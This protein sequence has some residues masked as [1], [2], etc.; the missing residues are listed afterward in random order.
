MSV[1]P[2]RSFVVMTGFRRLDSIETQF[3]LPRLVMEPPLVADDHPGEAPRAAL[4]AVLLPA[5]TR[6]EGR[7]YVLFS[8]GRDSSAIL[9]VAVALA[10]RVGADDPLPVTVIHPNAPGSDEAD[11]QRL[12]LDHL[13]IGQRKVLKFDGEQAW[14]GDSAAHSLTQNGLLWPP[15]VHLHGAI[16]SN[17]EPGAAVVS[18]EGGDLAIEGRRVTPLV[19]AARELRPRAAFRALAD[20]FRSS[21][22]QAIAGLADACRWLTPEGRR[23]FS[24]VYAHSAEPLRWDRDLYRSVYSRLAVMASVNFRAKVSTSGLVPLNPFEEPRFIAALMRVGGRFGLGDRTA[25]MRALFGDLLPAALLARTSKA[26]FNETRWSAVEQ[27]FAAD[28]D[29]AG[30]DPMYNDPALLRQEWLSETP[31]TLSAFHLHAAWL[32]SHGLPLV[33]DDT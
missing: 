18:G 19:S 22:R 23:T 14:L 27:G 12:V 30:I 29:G 7:C 8:G 11:W 28:W 21:G 25:M 4:E 2:H 33:P 26:Y 1:G 32:A 15:A 13:D 17:L 31:F 9:A 20:L 5:L 6:S 24:E 3:G 16:Y 10:R